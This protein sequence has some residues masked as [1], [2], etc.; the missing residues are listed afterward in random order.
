[1][2]TNT[3]VIINYTYRI[4]CAADNLFSFNWEDIMS[5]IMRYCLYA[6]IALP[7]STHSQLV[8]PAPTNAKITWI[9]EDT[10]EWESYINNIPTTTSNETSMMVI[11]GLTNLGYQ[12]EFVKATGDRADK[13]LQDEENTCMSDRIKTPYREKFSF[14]SIPHDL[15]LAQKLYRLAQLPLLGPKELN[16]QGEVI[17]LAHLFSNH[18]KKILATASGTSYGIELDR[19]ISELDPKNVFVRSG[20]RR[21]VMLAKMLFR[22]RVDYIIYY[23]QEINEINKKNITLESYTIAGSPSY[24]LGHVACAKT[25]TGKQIIADID[26]ILQQAYPT[27]EFYYAHKKWLIKS[28]LPKLRQHFFE[29]FNYLPNN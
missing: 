26:E 16:A 25:K 5:L 2:I 29:V 13:L 20:S 14:F 3:F 28:D 17:S 22:S 27:K 7:L 24:F 11:K 15:Y 18:P 6:I 1:V 23:P 10:H 9:I 19:Q 4:S 8:S 12:L 21:I